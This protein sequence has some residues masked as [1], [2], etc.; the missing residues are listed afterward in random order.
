MIG[1]LLGLLCRVLLES[2]VLLLVAGALLVVFSYRIG[3]RVVVDRPD[4]L[5]RFVMGAP[6]LLLLLVQVVARIRA[7]QGVESAV[8]N[9]SPEEATGE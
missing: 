3:R 6:P 7:A 5:D 1:R 8:T 4:R 2:A 9:V